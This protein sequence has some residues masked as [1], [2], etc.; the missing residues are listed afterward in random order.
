MWEVGIAG[1]YTWNQNLPDD[2]IVTMKAIEIKVGANSE[3]T[4]KSLY[5][6]DPEAALL[7]IPALLP[8]M[9]PMLL[10]LRPQVRRLLRLRLVATVVLPIL[11]L[12]KAL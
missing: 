9:M 4:L 12:V 11:L 8:R 5:L 3:L 1:A 6:G 2:G 10:L 7:L